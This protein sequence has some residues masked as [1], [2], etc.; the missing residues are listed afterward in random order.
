[1][2]PIGILACKVEDGKLISEQQKRILERWEQYFRTLMKMD[3]K[4]EGNK[5]K[6][7]SEVDENILP[8]PTYQRQTT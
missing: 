7:T 2:I 1:M 5:V 3:K 4:F 6:E 8:S